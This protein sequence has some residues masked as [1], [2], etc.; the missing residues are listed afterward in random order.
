LQESGVKVIVLSR[1]TNPV[2][3]AR[4]KKLS[5]LCFQGEKDSL[6][7]HGDLELASKLIDAACLANCEAA[8]LQKRPPE[9]CVPKTQ[10]HVR[11][12]TPWRDITSLE[13]RQRLDLSREDFAGLERY[14]REKKIL[15][16]AFCRHEPSVDF[17]EL[18]NPVCYNIASATP[19]DD[20]PV[21]KVNATHRSTIGDA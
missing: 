11:R 21:K 14:S 13:Y 17:M 20:Q 5:M 1:E 12:E 15:W 19:T 2:V 16:C 8:K 9:I 7:V 10:R 4:C 18:F 6:P 3:A